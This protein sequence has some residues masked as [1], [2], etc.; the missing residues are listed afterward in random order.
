M[1]MDETYQHPSIQLYIMGLKPLAGT[2]ENSAQG[3]D[4][5]VDEVETNDDRDVNGREC[6]EVEEVADFVN[7]K[8]KE[9]CDNIVTRLPNEKLSDWE[10]R[11]Y[12]SVAARLLHDIK[13]T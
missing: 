6:N 12:G 5:K 4:Q 10:A 2:S 1:Q 7:T 8:V 9:D 11:R 13:I 3:I